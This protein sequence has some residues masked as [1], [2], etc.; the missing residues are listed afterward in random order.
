MKKQLWEHRIPTIPAV[1]I[2][3]VSIW[4]TLWFIQKGV[5]TT[6][7]ASPDNVPSHVFLGNIT[8][9]SFAVG[10]TTS[11]QTAAAVSVS[12]KNGQTSVYFDNRA[13]GTNDPT[14]YTSHLFTVNNLQPGTEYQISILIAGK[15]Y[16]DNGKP[17]TL[18]TGPKLAQK[19]S[20]SPTIKGLIILPDGN[21]AS[22]TLVVAVPESGQTL[23]TLSQPSGN[24][25]IPLNQARTEDLNK[26]LTFTNNSNIQL[27]AFH[28]D[29]QS[30]FSTEYSSAIS[31]PPITLSENYTF[32]PNTIEQN[33]ATSS[34]V[35]SIPAAST[36]SSNQIT[37]TSPQDGETYV[38]SQPTFRG[39]ALPNQ[40]VDIIVHSDP[41]EAEVLTDTNGN[42]SYRPMNP[43]SQGN[44][45]ITIQSTDNYGIIRSL[46]HSFSIFPSGSQVIQSATPSATPTVVTPT[47]TQAPSP[48]PITTIPPTTSIT[49]TPPTATPTSTPTP[50]VVT[51]TTAP[52]SPAFTITPKE[53]GSSTP[54][55][56]TFVSVLMI[57]VGATLLF[58]VS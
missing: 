6:T 58:I 43:L 10:F 45:T 49:E 29:A 28:S 36:G 57:V 40:K 13:S 24:Y 8:D 50:Q 3:F 9:T 56:V 55:V 46:T 42:W 12:P 54:I 30:T 26:L 34:A 21:P 39:T 22:D 38:D 16:N 37:I 48:T 11:N 1:I 31:I 27:Q 17:Y 19:S 35:F 18:T 4:V 2:V 41:F 5:S 14:P 20:Q 7:H 33:E 23:L 53:P 32:V 52:I 25:S 15:T 44:H 51:P 47:P